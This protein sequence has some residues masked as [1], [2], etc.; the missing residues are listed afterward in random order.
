MVT[1]PNRT[2]LLPNEVEEPNRANEGANVYAN[3]GNHGLRRKWRCKHR[4]RRK[5]NGERGEMKRWNEGESLSE[6]C[7]NEVIWGLSNLGV[8]YFGKL[9]LVKE[10]LNCWVGKWNR[11]EREQSF[12][13]KR[14]TETKVDRKWFHKIIKIMFYIKWLKMTQF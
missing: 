2:F 4:S 14:G 1:G 5:E 8:S 10:I 12:T 7:E 13:K 11:K 9:I 3:E 6:R